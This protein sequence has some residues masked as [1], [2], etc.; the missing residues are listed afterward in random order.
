VT[1]A[2]R[3]QRDTDWGADLDRSGLFDVDSANIP[4]VRNVTVEQWLEDDRSKSYIATL[5]EPIRMSLLAKIEQIIRDRFPG[6]H[7]H[8]PYDTLLWI[9][10]KK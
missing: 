7:M 6:G 9:A 1:I 3:T 5:P 8:I 10:R 4:W 2:R